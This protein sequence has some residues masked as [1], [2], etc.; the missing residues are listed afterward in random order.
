MV[1]ICAT[2]AEDSPSENDIL[3]VAIW[4]RRLALSGRRRS[5]GSGGKFGRFYIMS[6]RNGSCLVYRSH[7]PSWKDRTW[8]Q[9][10][11][12]VD[13]ETY[14]VGLYLYLDVEVAFAVFVK[15]LLEVLA[16]DILR[17]VSHEETHLND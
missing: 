5:R 16:S 6:T 14:R 17:N 11:T 13:K 10:S 15:G 8:S 2:R 4:F 7:R 3:S 1:A 12:E 9:K